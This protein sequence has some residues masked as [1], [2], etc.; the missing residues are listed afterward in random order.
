MILAL[1]EFS[2]G[3][4]CFF[5]VVFDGVGFGIL[6]LEEEGGEEGMY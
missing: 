5:F 6:D 3:G 1:E 2:R 4:L